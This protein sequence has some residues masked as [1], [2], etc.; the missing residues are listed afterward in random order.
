MG[1]MG[2]D[3]I[4]WVK[5]GKILRILIVKMKGTITKKMAIR[6]LPPPCPVGHLLEPS[7]LVIVIHASCGG[8]MGLLASLPVRRFSLLF[9]EELLGTLPRHLL[10]FG[11][12]EALLVTV[13]P[14][15]GCA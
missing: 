11:N 12:M 9:E 1:Y 2:Q 6:N 5:E 15:V 4:R 8:H 3:D 13:T 7:S 14:S 10:L